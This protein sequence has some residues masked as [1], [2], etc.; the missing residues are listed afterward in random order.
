MDRSWWQF[1]YDAW[2]VDEKMVPGVVPQFLLNKTGCKKDN[3]W[4][5]RHRRGEEGLGLVEKIIGL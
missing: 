5:K 2:M 4:E 1:G 3:S